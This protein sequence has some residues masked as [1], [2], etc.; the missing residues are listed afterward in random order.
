MAALP[1][2]EAA[3]LAVLATV[4]PIPVLPVER[5]LAQPSSEGLIDVSNT[6][7]TRTRLNK[8][9]FEFS[10]NG[11]IFVDSMIPGRPSTTPAVFLKFR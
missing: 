1:A 10:F 3:V 7:V 5:V 11:S 2:V 6:P 8:P 9:L 4:A